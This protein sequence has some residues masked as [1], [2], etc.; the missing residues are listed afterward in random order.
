MFKYIPKIAMVLPPE[1]IAVW[2][3]IVSIPFAN[4]LTTIMSCLTKVFD[5]IFAR[6]KHSF[7]A[8]LEP[9]TETLLFS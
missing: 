9:T 1:S 2:W 8:A 3:A 6:C 7:E 4:P 5:M